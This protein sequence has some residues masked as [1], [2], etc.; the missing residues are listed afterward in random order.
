MR[1]RHKGE[2]VGGRAARWI[3][4]EC[5]KFSLPIEGNEFEG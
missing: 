3:V 5:V 2:E 1:M 4:A